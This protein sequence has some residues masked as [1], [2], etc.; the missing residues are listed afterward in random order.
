[1]LFR[2]CRVQGGRYAIDLLPVGDA[3]DPT[4]RLVVRRLAKA[5]NDF[6]L[7]SDQ[8]ALVTEIFRGFLEAGAIYLRGTDGLVEAVAILEFP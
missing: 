5:V 4:P 6:T 2:S 8:R 1:M 7:D 3:D